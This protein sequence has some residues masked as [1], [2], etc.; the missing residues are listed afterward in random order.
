MSDYHVAVFGGGSVGLCLAASFVKAG[1]RVT[2][3]V[4]GGSIPALTDQPITVSGLLGDHVIESD[5]IT[6]CDA[7]SPTPDVLDSDMLVLT[8]KAYD[9]ADALRPFAVRGKCPPLLL[10]QNGIGSAEIAQGIVGPDVPIYSTAMMIGMVRQSPG[11]V[12]VT[13]QSSPINCGPLLGHDLGPLHAMLDVA[14]S[15]FVPMVHDERIRETIASKVLFNSCMNPTGAL[16]GQTYGQLLTD[17]HSR[18][19]IVALADETLATFEAAYGY[20]PARDGQDYVDNILSEI[21]F[22]RGVGHLSSMLQDLRAGRPTEIAFLNGAIA[23]L[24]KT[25]GLTTPGHQM[26][27]R[28]IKAAET[29]SL[30]P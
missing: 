7:A 15:G 17:D 21:I 14:R 11:Q 6:L 22:P 8:T 10:L 26:I 3:L 1:A 23:D 16:T 4:R 24:A 30:A 13:A 18:A 2:L 29:T 19:V 5:A 20:V 25:V 9:V 27:L 12:A 28:L